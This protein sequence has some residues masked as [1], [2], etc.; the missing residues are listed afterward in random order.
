MII[1]CHLARLDK[2]EGE[3]AKMDIF[4]TLRVDHAA[5]Q[6]LLDQVLESNESKTDWAE[7]LADLKISLVAH[8]RAEE[9]ILYE[10]MRGAPQRAETADLKTEEHHLAEEILDDL[11]RLN[12]A[13]YDWDTT[14]ALLKNQIESH[15]AEEETMVFSSLTPFIDDEMSE[16]MAA[17]FTSLRDD[18][19]EGAPYHP[20]GRSII[21]PAGL[22]LNT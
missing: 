20:R 18:I 12:P 4:E 19:I 9:A 16:K 22:D 2:T 13:D 5:I 8:N 7:A 11:D 6:D 1:R 3:E 21:N 15:I 10:F 14:L 17:D